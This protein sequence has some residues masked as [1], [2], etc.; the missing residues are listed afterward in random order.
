M[1]AFELD[2][3]IARC[4]ARLGA[5]G[6]KGIAMSGL[7]DH[8]IQELLLQLLDGDQ[9]HRAKVAHFMWLEEKLNEGERQIRQQMLLA[10]VAPSNGGANR[11]QRR[12]AQ[13]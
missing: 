6:Q 11:E 2:E 9:L 4:E 13:P 5:L 8:W 3:L 12:A 7:S 10:G 1:N